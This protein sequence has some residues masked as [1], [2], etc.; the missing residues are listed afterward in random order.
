MRRLVRSG[1]TLI[2]ILIVVAIIGVL[3][4][5]LLG[6][7]M[8]T[9]GRGEVAQAENFVNNVIPSAMGKWQ[10]NT[11]KSGNSYPRSPSLSDGK[12]YWLGNAE[13]YNE[14]VTKPENRNRSAFLESETYIEGERDGRPVF[15][16]PWNN[17]YIYRNY[18]GVKRFSG[19]QYNPGTYDLISL[20]RDEE[21]GTEDD[22]HNGTE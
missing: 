6:V 3:V 17:P 19:H 14:L 8:S 9:A 13:L 22:I 20:G 21:L 1:F 12:D 5:V 18:A 4:T 16:D 2:E 7:L 11:G 15:L 10:N